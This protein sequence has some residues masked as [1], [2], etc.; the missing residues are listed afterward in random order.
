[1]QGERTVLRTKKQHRPWRVLHVAK[2]PSCFCQSHTHPR[3]DCI[4]YL[5]ES[6]F[7][8]YLYAHNVSC[9]TSTGIYLIMAGR[10]N[11]IEISLFNLDKFAEERNS[12]PTTT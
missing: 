7:A 10:C 8:Y 3:N 5:Q 4:L 1:M 2:R 11:F 9:A 12:I 6:A